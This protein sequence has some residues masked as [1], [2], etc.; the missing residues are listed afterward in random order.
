MRLRTTISSMLG[1]I[2]ITNGILKSS[3]H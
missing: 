2:S 1:T 3:M